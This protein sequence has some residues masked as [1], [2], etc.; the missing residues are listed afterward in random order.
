M[1][2]D[3]YDAPN[4]H[5]HSTIA[6]DCGEHYNDVL[7][8]VGERHSTHFSAVFDNITLTRQVD[9][10]NGVPVLKPFRMFKLTGE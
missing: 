9:Y 10:V 8:F 3:R 6:E 4:L 2:W 5:Y 1:S 7:G